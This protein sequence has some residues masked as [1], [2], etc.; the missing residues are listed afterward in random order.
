M[1]AFDC[2]AK[3][4][5]FFKKEDAVSDLAISKVQFDAQAGRLYK[6]ALLKR[7]PKNLFMIIPPEYSKLGSLPP[8]WIVDSLMKHLK[9]NYYLGLLSAASMYGATHHQP[10]NCQVIVSRHL[11]NISLSRGNIE[12]HMSK[13]CNNAQITQIKTNI[14]YTQIS[15]KEQTILDLLHFYPHCGYFSNVVQVIKDL[16]I[17]K[18]K[19]RNLVAVL[20]LE[21]ENTVIQRLGY[22]MEYLGFENIANVVEKE[23]ENRKVY[24]TLLRPDFASKI[25][26]KSKRWKVI[27]NNTIELEE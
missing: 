7:F 12:F 22:V 17:E 1:Y 3:G 21:P 5:Y 25:G 24:Y 4:K 14:G 20:K 19:I 2:I 8:Y 26:E 11:K 16:V 10:M 27:L 6:K 15:T 18:I 13:N 9:V 23:L